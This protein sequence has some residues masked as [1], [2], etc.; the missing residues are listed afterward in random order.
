MCVLQ[1]VSSYH[2]S[3]GGY[4]DRGCLNETRYWWSLDPSN[5]APVCL[6]CMELNWLK[7]LD[8]PWE[9][10][11]LLVVGPGRWPIRITK[12][13]ILY[14][15]VWLVL[16]LLTSYIGYIHKLRI[17]RIKSA[18]TAADFS[19]WILFCRLDP[20]RVSVPWKALLRILVLMLCCRTGETWLEP[21]LVLKASGAVT[22][23]YTSR[24]TLSIY[25]MSEEGKPGGGKKLKVL[26]KSHYCSCRM[27]R[28]WPQPLGC[29]LL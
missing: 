19:V 29:S 25:Q 15:I 28:R 24:H 3:L 17:R 6:A 1:V 10:R 2:C 13:I 18:P 27:T 12:G 9:K 26:C 22:A 11:Q 20:T 4:T 8:E 23:L 14:T 21:G 7:E 5:N 16:S